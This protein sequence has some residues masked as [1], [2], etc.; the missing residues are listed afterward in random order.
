MSMCVCVCLNLC[1][2][3]SLGTCLVCV[4]FYSLGVHLVLHS[5][6]DSS[7]HFYL[8][9][10]F[11]S[12]SFLLSLHLSMPVSSF[13]SDSTP[14]SLHIYFWCLS[15]SLHANITSPCFLI[16]TTPY[17]T[18]TPLSL[19][20]VSLSPLHDFTSVWFLSCSWIIPFYFEL[21]SFTFAPLGVSPKPQGSEPGRAVRR[22]QPLH[23]WVDRWRP[24]LAH[25]DGLC[26]YILSR[27]VFLFCFVYLIKAFT[28]IS[29]PGVHCVSCVNVNLAWV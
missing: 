20:C 29:V 11:L 4:I 18:H 24:L 28:S 3:T 12:P 2:F 16:T 6:C 22:I 9:P 7:C 21:W 10:P 27:L 5:L 15:L 19:L 17:N 14:P 26:R 8:H 25:E 1:W 23:Q 13:I